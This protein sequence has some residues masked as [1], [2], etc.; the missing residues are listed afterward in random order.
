MGKAS[1]TIQWPRS[2][3]ITGFLLV[4]MLCSKELKATF[5]LLL[6][7][8]LYQKVF[9]VAFPF[10]SRFYGCEQ[11]YDQAARICNKNGGRL[12]LPRSADENSKVGEGIN[13]EKRLLFSQTEPLFYII[14]YQTELLFDETKQI[15]LHTPGHPFSPCEFAFGKV[16]SSFYNWMDTKL[17][18]LTT[19][20]GW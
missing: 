12:F 18:N 5:N 13:N 7:S 3:L 16:G 11:T 9:L 19:Q 10:F 20:P 14:F 2:Q 6:L 8:I 15:G 17:A 4:F 1:S